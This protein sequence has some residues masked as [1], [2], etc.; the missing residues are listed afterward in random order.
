VTEVIAAILSVLASSSPA[1]RASVVPSPPPPPPAAPALTVRQ[2]VGQR[3]VFAYDGLKPPPALRQRIRRGEAAGVIIFSRNVRSAAQLRATTRSLQAIERPA[4]LRAPLIVM[5]DQE[6]GPVRRIPGPPPSATAQSHSEAAARADGRATARTLRRAGVNLDLAPVADVGRPGAALVREHRTHGSSPRRVAKLVTAFAAGLREGGVLAT[7]KHFPGLGSS[8]VNTDAA[9]AHI[10]LALGTL[11][12]V[13][14]APFA[15]L[16][17]ADVDAI[18]L[19]TAVYPALDARPAAFSGRWIR[20]ELRER[21][22]FRGVTISD[23]LQTPAVQSFGSIR[24]RAVRAANAGVDVPLFVGTYAA[25]AEAADGLVAAARS[26]RLSRAGLERT[27]ER[28]LAL[29]SRLKR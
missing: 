6:S 26:G 15:S 24:Q 3:F 27:A 20:S 23:D 10:G 19:A 4:G 14:E 18:M 2:L 5:T 12:S 17:S 25:G 11:R 1:L 13:D 7:A 28:V 9:P 29:R 21:L 8:K 16:I 22:G